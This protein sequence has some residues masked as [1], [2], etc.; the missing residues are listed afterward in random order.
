MRGRYPLRGNRAL[1]LLQH[2]WVLCLRFRVLASGQI[3]FLYGRVSRVRNIG[4][5]VVDELL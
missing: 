1:G 4:I 3:P 5:W 2:V